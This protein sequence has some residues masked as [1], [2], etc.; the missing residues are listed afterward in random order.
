MASSSRAVR[1]DVTSDTREFVYPTVRDPEYGKGAES[2][3]DGDKTGPVKLLD[4]ADLVDKQRLLL[5]FLMTFKAEQ[6][7]KGR[8]YWEK[9]IFC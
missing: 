1:F 9:I 3:G 2:S 5:K 8:S 6:T 4:E 7:H